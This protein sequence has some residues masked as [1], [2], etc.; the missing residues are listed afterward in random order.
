MRFPFPPPIIMAPADSARGTPPTA[1]AEVV[2]FRINQG[3]DDADFI[4]MARATTSSPSRC[5]SVVKQAGSANSSIA[6]AFV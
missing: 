4:S 6:R 1:I 5:A 3:I 2:S